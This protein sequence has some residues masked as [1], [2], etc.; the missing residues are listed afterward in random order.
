[1]YTRTTLSNHST[2]ITIPNDYTNATTVL[3]LFPVGS[4]YETQE[5]NG[6]SHFIEHMMFKGT[7]KRPTTLD[8]SRELDGFGAEY[9]AYTSKDFTG[10]YVRID[11][12]RLDT[13]LDIVS[14]M[15]WNSKFDAEEIEREKGVIAEELHMY[16]DNPMMDIEECM[17]AQLFCGSP[18]EWKIGGTDTIIHTFTREG[19]VGFRDRFYTP[20]NMT[21]VIAGKLPLD[22]NERAERY[23]GASVR[24]SAEDKNNYIHHTFIDSPRVALK[25]KET[26]QAVMCLGFRGVSYDDSRLQALKLLHIILGATMSSR[27]FTEVRERRGLAYIVKTDVTAYRETGV[28]SVHAGLLPEKSEE[29]LQTIID[30]LKKIREQGITP[31]ELQRAKENMRGRI[32][33]SLENSSELAEWYGK[34]WS[35]RGQIET[36]SERCKKIDAVTLDEVTNIAREVIQFDQ[37]KLAMIGTFKDATPFE[38]ILKRAI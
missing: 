10:Y 2:L 8:I 5:L 1:M 16:E 7:T 26:E 24:E 34:Q 23:F 9:N 29:A 11:T 19:M 32:T 14:D 20:Q 30:E 27:L 35:L 17:E 31:E 36:P 38:N 13:A 15:L 22:I 28:F 25:W 21:V 3:V 18:L 4:R 33:L 37:A 6:V 12:S